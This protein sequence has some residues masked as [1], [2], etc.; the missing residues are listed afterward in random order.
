M[1]ANTHP[2]ARR[3]RAVTDRQPRPMLDEAALERIA[4]ALYRYVAP[5]NS[6]AITPVTFL[7]LQHLDCPAG[8][9]YWSIS[10][11]GPNRAFFC[12]WCGVQLEPPQ[13]VGAADA[14]A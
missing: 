2:P 11:S 8:P 3:S 14:A 13:A 7:H 10:D 6:Y 5:S 1:S 9:G 12:P 4:D